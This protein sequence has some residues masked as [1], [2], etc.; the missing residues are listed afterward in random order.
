MCSSYLNDSNYVLFFVDQI[1][2]FGLVGIRKNI[3]IVIVLCGES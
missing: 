1:N 2:G 3:R